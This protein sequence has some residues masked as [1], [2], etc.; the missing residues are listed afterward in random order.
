MSFL[1]FIKKEIMEAYKTP[2][3]II[4]CALFLL[5]GIMSPLS[6]KYMNEI[7]AMVG[8]QQ[9]IS[10]VLPEPTYVQSYEQFFKNI[11]FMMTIVTILVFAGAVAEEKA[12]GT[13][14]LVL[15]K[16]LS[17][18]GFIMG[19]L[20]AAVLVFTFSYAVST[21]IC[22]Y[23]T[24][25]MFPQYMSEAVGIAL[26]LYWIF[27]CMMI[28]VTL[29]VSILSKSMTMAAVSGFICY[30]LIS[31]L[32]SIPYIGKYTPGILQALST[33]L[34][35]GAKTPGEAFLPALI[36]AAAGVAA[37]ITGLIAFRRQEL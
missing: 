16:C 20:I 10:I 24:S 33:E 6:A 7:L 1:V 32:S 18:S 2:K 8:Q 21:A 9:G 31:A 25:L 19:K 13:A 27:G 14:V 4:L 35:M 28:A 34:S 30:A 11:Y 15:T 26:L 29:L 22:I 17:R 3:V 37:V 5:F 36:T 23:Y 12:K